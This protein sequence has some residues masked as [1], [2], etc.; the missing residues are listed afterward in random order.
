M[1]AFNNTI[2]LT[3]PQGLHPTLRD[4]YLL[5]GC[6]GTWNLGFI[7]PFKS[8]SCLVTR[9]NYHFILPALGLE[10]WQPA[11]VESA[12]LRNLNILIFSPNLKSNKKE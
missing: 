10:P 12:S 11:C 9:S 5:I 7:D 2:C 4:L 1:L 6:N 8:L 3:H